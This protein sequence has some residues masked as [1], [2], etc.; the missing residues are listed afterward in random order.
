MNTKNF[1]RRSLIALTALC[2]FGAAQASVVFVAGTDAFSLHNDVSFINPVLKTLQGASTKSV[3]VIGN[4]SFTNTSGVATV[5]G[6]VNLTAA[7]ASTLSSYSA[8][9]FQSPCCSDPAVRL[10]GFQASVDAFVD[11]GGG[12]FIEDY[13]GNALW[14]S[15]LNISTT[16]VAAKVNN[17]LAC[18]DP[19]VST[20]SGLAFGFNA[21]Y[22]EGCFVHQTYVNSYW[23]GEGFFAL[24]TG[25]NGKFVTMARGFADP[26]P[27][28]VPEPASIALAGFALLGLM[29][30][31]RRNRRN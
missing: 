10:N 17:N 24:Q 30:A 8:I 7:F 13:Q 9:I 28:K 29:A 5:N 11:A 21:S 23:T 14:D 18:I 3:L 6:G 1:L 4:D 12:I 19:G 26:D 15:I 2:T 27:A 22:S 31:R 25:D 20:A 16:T